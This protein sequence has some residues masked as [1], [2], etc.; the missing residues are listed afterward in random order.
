MRV[1]RQWAS[2]LLLAVSLSVGAS[3][4]CLAAA[5]EQLVYWP[6]VTDGKEYRRVS[7]PAEAGP[8]LVLAD[9]EVVIEARVAPVAYWPITREYLADFSGR[10]DPVAGSVEIVDGAGEVRAIEPEPHVLWHPLGV[11]VGPAQLVRGA[12]AEEL[13]EDYLR[14]ARAAAAKEQQYQRIVGAHRAAVEAWLRLAAERRGQDMPAPPPELDVK[15]PEPYPAYATE[16]RVAAV[17]ALPEGAYTVRIR[18]PEG[19]NVPQCS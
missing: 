12:A 2:A 11:G 4:P 1:G 13:Y 5:H 6:L 17:V 18:D 3:A 8:L 14:A 7:Y 10:P 15:P 19:G 9:T 16:P